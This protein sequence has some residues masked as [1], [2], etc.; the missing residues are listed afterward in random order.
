PLAHLLV[1]SHDRGLSGTLELC[2][3]DARSTVVLTSGKPTKARVHL[4]VPYLGRVL[5]ERGHI[6]EQQ[7]DATLLDLAKTRRLHG[8]I[9]LERGHI[10]PQALRDGLREQLLRKVD[11]LFDLP[12]QTTFEYF[13]SY[14]ALADYGGPEEVYG[15]PYAIVWRGIRRTPSW[16]H[17]QTTLAHL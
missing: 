12:P 14:D 1:Y 3:P 13:A 10:T 16:D 6:T 4:P 5:L 15:D 8:R 17:V 11:A 9:L 7:L 2:L